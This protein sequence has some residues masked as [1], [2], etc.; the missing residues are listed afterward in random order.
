MDII[1]ILD[2][3]YFK[4][5]YISIQEPYI[6]Q[7]V[8]FIVPKNLIFRITLNALYLI[9]ATEKCPIKY[10]ILRRKHLHKNGSYYILLTGYNENF[11]EILLEIKIT[12]YVVIICF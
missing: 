2:I 3:I 6:I 8:R 10:P 11:F 5:Y 12:V 9:L 4:T 7:I 1:T